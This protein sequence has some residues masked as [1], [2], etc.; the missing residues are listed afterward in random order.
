MILRLNQMAG[1]VTFALVLAQA[2]L[3]GGCASHSVTMVKVRESLIAGNTALALEEFNQQKKKDSDLL[4]LLERGYLLHLNGQWEESNLAFESAE[5]RAD[6]L[7]TRS[8]TRNAAALI[9]SDNVLPYR[10]SFYELQLVQYYRAL[11]YLALGRPDEA[12]VE[13]R[14]S[15]F[16]LEQYS[17]VEEGQ[18]TARRNAFMH[19]MTGL[20][21]ESQGEVNDA[22]VSFRDA[23][24]LYNEQSAGNPMA[25][26]EWLDEDYYSAAEHLGL[27]EETAALVARRPTVGERSAAGDENNLVIFFESGFVPH[28]EPV[29]IIL[30]FFEAGDDDSDPWK[31]ANWYVDEYGSDIYA[32]KHP[33][34]KLDKVLRFSFPRLVDSPAEVSRCELLLPYGKSVA[35]E[36]MIDLGAVAHAEFNDR[37]PGIL[38]RTVARAIAKEVARKGA[39]DEGGVLAGAMVNIFNVAT[40]KADTRGWDFLP[41]RVDLVKAAVPPGPQTL[42]ARAIDKGGAVVDEWTVEIE[43]R[44]GDTQFISL[45]SFR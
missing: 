45:R 20:L 25:V 8:I 5:R 19:Y 12:L 26:P 41:A 13:A 15:N 39:K 21:Y 31:R 7:Y 3:L 34:V 40:E 16:M 23:Y 14:K 22:I 27:T 2:L 32:Y 37:L 42:V 29:D 17:G 9:T 30:P 6:E 28:R 38:L 18:A 44:R 35:A 10:G 11:N 33:A 24:R 36:Q 43:A 1:L 4:Y